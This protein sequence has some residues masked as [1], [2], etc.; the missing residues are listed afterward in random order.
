LRKIVFVLFCLLLVSS[1]L[2][3][4]I[5]TGKI[6][7]TVT[8]K[9]GAAL[10]G[11]SIEA[12]SPSLIS[13]ATATTDSSGVY[14]LLALQPGEYKITFTLAGF[15]PFIREKIE[16]HVGETLTVDV[17][18]EMGKIE[19]EVTVVGQSP[20]ID[21]KSTVKGMTLTKEMFQLLPKG[22]NFDSLVTAVPGVNYE[23]WLGGISVDGASGAE[24]QFYMD[25]TEITRIDTGTARLPAAF[26]F[27]DEVQIVASGYTAEFGGALGGVLSVVTRQGGNK[28]SGDVIGYYNSEWLAGKERDSLRTNPIDWHIAEYVNYQDMYGKDK[29]DRVEAGFDLGGYIIKDRLWFFASVLPVYNPTTRHVTFLSNGQTGDYTQTWW[30][31]NFQAKLTAQ[32]FSFMRIGGSFVNNF[33]KYRGNLPARDG[34]GNP[35]DVYSKYGFD[36]PD[37][38]A[39]GFADLTFGNNFM[40]NFRG[41][42]FYYNTTNQQ[43]VAS[44]PHWMLMGNG[45]HSFDGTALQIPDQYQRPT[46]WQNTGR[47]NTTVR[48]IKYKNYVNSDFTYYFRLGGEHSFKFGGSWTR[49]G[50][51]ELSAMA[52][53]DLP[54]VRI[55]W[56][57]PVIVGGINYGQGTYGYYEVRGNEATGPFGAQWNVH[58][59]RWALYATD[60]WTIANKLTLNYGL[61]AE[62]EYVPP[63]TA[64]VPATVSAG[65]NPMQFNWGDK[66]A[67]RVG[68]IYDVFGDASLK[69]FGSYGFYYDVIK[70]YSAAHAY[71]GFK[72]KSSYY[73]L[74]TYQWDTIG[75]GNYPGTQVLVYDWRY[76]SWDTTDPDTH[77]VSQREISFGL[78]KMIRENLSTT[79]RVV[80]KHLRYT[81][82][83]V[84]MIVP[85][86]GEEYYECSPGFGWSLHVGN[87][88]GKMDPAY[89]E[90]PKAKR[91]YLGITFSIDKRLSNNWLAGFSYTWSSLHGN[92]SGLAS[93]EEYGRVS[94]YVE[95]DFDNFSMAY[96]KD[97]LPNDGPLPTDRTHFF[98]FYGAYTFPFHITLG[99]VV[100]AYSGV[101]VT[102]SWNAFSTYE[103]PFGRGRI[104][105]KTPMRTPFMWFA[106][107]YAE[108]NMKLGKYGLQFNINVDNV[109]D[110]ATAQ[111]IY[112]YK[113]WQDLNVTQQQ[114]LAK[115]WDLTD[116]GVG[117]VQNP[118]YMM[119]T[120]FYGPIQARLGVKLSF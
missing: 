89:W 73:L 14:R 38:S 55:Y 88:T 66:L 69:I 57:R 112:E 96:T 99:A 93:S 116:P 2:V 51:D 79:I 52:Y 80:Q 78:E 85:G 6:I 56:G 102:E 46:G 98:K 54:E 5:P 48:E 44:D 84:G 18:M 86:V 1:F 100:N 15:R 101:P 67:P 59:T 108:Y 20:L 77:P 60:T 83:D 58:N 35:D 7:G 120:N 105:D 90:T 33:S 75:N 25:G 82:E 12:T 104:R 16:L 42:R 81:M 37:W 4:Q 91:E 40:A 49:Q 71:G 111:R 41:G 9:E 87:G 45:T 64:S 118:L 21:V 36:Y 97:G 61:R 119:P 10:P 3:A 29:F 30:S 32:P 94:P 70:T 115:N 43:V 74:D 68:F 26:D 65:W 53:P 76:P 113:T 24:N 39:Q 106:N 110:I 114:W 22:R 8:D 50:E 17:A 72:W 27:V 103:F 34:T 92:Y 117:F 63:Y 62:T 19:E 47:L 11:V 95:R 13:K 31:Y 109:F 23:P 107:I 28:Y